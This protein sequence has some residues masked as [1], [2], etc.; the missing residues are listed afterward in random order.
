M[1]KAT[2]EPFR[3]S[4]AFVARVVATRNSIG[5]NAA[6]SGV[7]VSRRAPSTGASSPERNSITDPTLQPS[8]TS[9]DSSSVRALAFHP[10]T[11]RA[12]KHSARNPASRPSHVPQSSAIRTRRASTISTMR[13]RRQPADNTL[14][15]VSDP[16]GRIAKQSVNVPP[17]SAEMRH[18]VEAP[19]LSSAFGKVTPSESM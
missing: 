3:S 9:S 4:K 10:T 17:V 2:R 14:Q 1:N 7:F 8:G 6:P 16:S 13:D 19:Y 5:G 15:R 18:M 11:T 12:S